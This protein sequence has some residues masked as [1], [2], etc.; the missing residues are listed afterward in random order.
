MHA[1]GTGKA[2]GT[3]NWTGRQEDRQA[4]GKSMGVIQKEIERQKRTARDAQT[5]VG[6][7]TDKVR[8]KQTKADIDCDS[9]RE[10]NKPKTGQVA[11][12]WTGAVLQY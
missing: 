11:E 7:P 1:C 5:N 6:K 10:T 9:E 12:G 2:K 4:D 8:E 3:E